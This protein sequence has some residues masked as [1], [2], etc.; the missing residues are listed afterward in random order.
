MSARRKSQLRLLMECGAT[1]PGR[2][3]AFLDVRTPMPAIDE[4]CGQLVI[5]FITTD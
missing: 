3:M 2:P 1:T 5:C 4:G